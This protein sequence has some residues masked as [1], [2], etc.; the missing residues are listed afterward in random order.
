MMVSIGMGW[1]VLP[2][3]MVD[4][5]LQILDVA[6]VVS[7]RQLGVIQHRKRQLSNAALAFIEAIVVNGDL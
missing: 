6:E 2:L 1:S 7:A 4:S 3:S 5:H